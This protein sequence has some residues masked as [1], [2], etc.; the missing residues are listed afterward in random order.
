M[1]SWSKENCIHAESAHTVAIAPP[2]FS[3][4]YKNGDRGQTYNFSRV[5]H[6]HTNQDEYF[7][8]TA[9]PLVRLLR[10]A[11]CASDGYVH[12]QFCSILLG[13]ES[14]DVSNSNHYL[15]GSPQLSM[16]QQGMS[17]CSTAQHQAHSSAQ[18]SPAQSSTNDP[19]SIRYFGILNNPARLL[20]QK[21]HCSLVHPVMRQ[22]LVHQTQ[23]NCDYG[24]NPS[25]SLPLFKTTKH[26]VLVQTCSR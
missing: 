21:Q 25:Q 5:F 15:S 26:F 24:S 11:I 13:K 2:E 6:E 7:Q 22:C 19:C 9:A 18:P 8:A 20:S 3:Q 4:G 16:L 10:L 1:P 17:T 23:L 14:A 12:L